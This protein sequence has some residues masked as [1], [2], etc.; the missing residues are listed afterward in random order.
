MRR[1]PLLLLAVV[2]ISLAAT[3]AAGQGLDSEIQILDVTEGAGGEI[4]LDLAIPASIGELAPIES[5][6]GVTDGGRLVEFTIAPMTEAVDAVVVL[7]TSGSMEGSALA[8]AR[9]A[10]S[11]FIEELPAKARVGVVS[12]GETAVVHRAPSLDRGAALADVDGLTANG[13]T[14]L[15]D[16]LVAAADLLTGLDTDRPYVVLLSDGDDTVSSATRDE[17]VAELQAASA[18]LYAVAIESPDADLAALGQAV[19]AVGGQFFT[20]ADIGELDALY[21]DIA[22]R[23]SSRYRLQFTSDTDAARTVVVSVATGGAIATARTTIGVG[24]G[25]GGAADPGPAPVINVAEDATLG[26]VP[27][28]SPGLLGGASAFKLGV[29]SMFLAL[30]VLGLLMV[31]PS[32]Q[33]K[34]DTAVGADRVAGFNSRLSLAADR[35][36]SRRDSEGELD[37]M[38]DAAGLHLRPGEFVLLSLLGVVLTSLAASVVGGLVLGIVVAFAATV[39]VFGYLTGR[40]ARRRSKFADQ[41]TDTLGI[42]SGAL[43]AGRGLPQAIELVSSEAP[44]PTAEQ[45]RRIVFESRVGR[46]LTES[47]MGVAK[48]MK[49]EDLEWVARAVDINRELGGDL[50]EM[51]DN[52]AD[53]IRDRRRVARQVQALSAEGRASGW[54]LLALPVVM[55]LFVSWRTPDNAVLMLEEPLG[56]LMLAGAVFGMAVGY[57]WIRK[58]VDLK[59]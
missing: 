54:V 11:T 43:R 8:A 6:F 25:D 49:S 23:L 55:F 3:P 53:T 24:V 47:M 58:L 57:F 44:S 2:V 36:I 26:L 38:L 46:D 42:M 59:Y 35:F 20:T 15:W 9:A 45:F 48:R 29:G 14:A 33:V 13:E 18:A 34:L 22:G 1:L 10:A 41:L 7:D 37:K 12:F 5:N 4:T 27:A 39:A 30:V 21:T 52:V 19:D 56:R 16:G 31:A 51:L 28:P 40:A 17:A 50:T 32:T